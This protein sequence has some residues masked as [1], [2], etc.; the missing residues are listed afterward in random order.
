M[1]LM[2]LGLPRK[3]GR[4]VCYEGRVWRSAGVVI[5]R[6]SLWLLAGWKDAFVCRR[7]V[8]WVLGM[9]GKWGS[10]LG[11]PAS[12][13]RVRSCAGRC[14]RRTL[15]VPQRAASLRCLG[16]RRVG[17]NAVAWLGLGGG[18]RSPWPRDLSAGSQSAHVGPVGVGAAGASVVVDDPLGFAFPV[19]VLV[20]QV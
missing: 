13:R 11:G 6:A 18:C 15:D 19:H 12:C 3:C 2:A 14:G 16:Q 7:G 8:A 10:C 9:A 1:P 5:A 4:S 17:C 20:D